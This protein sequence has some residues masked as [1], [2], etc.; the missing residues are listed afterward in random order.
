MLH[1]Y[2][3]VAQYVWYNVHIQL[4]FNTDEDKQHVSSIANDYLN[5][6]YNY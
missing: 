4:I 1:E 5:C 3:I 6:E 2:T